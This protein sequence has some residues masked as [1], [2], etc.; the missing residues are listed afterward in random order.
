MIAPL[1]R[2]FESLHALLLKMAGYVEEAM[3]SAVRALLARDPAAARR[4]IAGDD[5]IDLMEN[6][7][8]EEC[9]K[10]LSMNQHK[11]MNLRRISSVMLITTDL[12]R[13]GDLAVGI[14]KRTLQIAAPPYLNV[15]EGLMAMAGTSCEMVRRALDSF[16]QL[17]AGAARAVIRLD[18]EVDSANGLLIGAFAAEMKRSPDLVDSGISMIAVVRHLERIADHATAIAEDVIYLVEGSIVRHHPEAI[19]AN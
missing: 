1:P 16:V 17:D 10:L 12:E 7:L 3:Y 5:A 15:P 6:G 11:D 9:L 13:I 19:A 4:I 8:F 2:D 14:A 18:D